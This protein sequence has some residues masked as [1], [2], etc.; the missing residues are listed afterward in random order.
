[1][2]TEILN[3]E[4]DG[5]FPADDDRL[6][7]LLL[8][9]GAYPFEAFDRSDKQIKEKVGGRI[10]LISGERESHSYLKWATENYEKI[11]QWKEEQQIAFKLK[12]GDF[13]NTG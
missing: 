7:K 12:Y 4:V 2:L 3:R 1:M 10:V 6:V 5:F 8:E 13:V 9:G 11:K